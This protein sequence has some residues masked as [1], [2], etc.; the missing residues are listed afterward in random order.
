ML[1][2]L[3]AIWISTCV[4]N[5]GPVI[6]ADQARIDRENVIESQ[7]EEGR[8]QMSPDGKVKVYE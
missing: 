2:I 4:V 5:E 1:V 8:F 6:L 7:H 3:A